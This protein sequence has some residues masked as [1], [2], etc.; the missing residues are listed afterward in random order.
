MCLRWT[1]TSEKKAVINELNEL[2]KQRGIEKENEKIVKFQSA[3][4]WEWLKALK[5]IVK[6]M[7]EF[8][9]LHKK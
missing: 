9:E 1:K 5:P 2:F 4:I 8:L 6:E 3:L 7:E